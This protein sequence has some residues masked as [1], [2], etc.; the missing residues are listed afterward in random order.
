MKILMFAVAL[1]LCILAGCSDGPVVRE[2]PPP[3]IYIKDN[4][5]R[6]GPANIHSKLPEVNHDLSCD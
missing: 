3:L 2:N 6:P 4:A 1:M 5:D